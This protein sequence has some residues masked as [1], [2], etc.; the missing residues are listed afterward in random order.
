MA[1]TSDLPGEKK[2]EGKVKRAIALGYGEGDEAPKVLAS[3]QGVIAEQ[4][5]AVAREHQLPVKEDPVLAQA[6]SQVDLNQ[7]I[8]PELYAVVAEV[9]AFVYRVRQKKQSF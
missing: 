6:L 9:F 1:K 2:E 5:L 4:I 3:G 7:M 8:P